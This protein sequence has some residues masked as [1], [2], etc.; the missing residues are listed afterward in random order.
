M[1]R[2]GLLAALVGF[3]TVGASCSSSAPTKATPRTTPTAEQQARADQLLPGPDWY[4][5]AV[6]YEV[7][8]RSFTDSNGDGIGDLVGLITRLDYLKSLGVDAIWLMPIM[9]TPF[10]DSGYDVSD[11]RKISPDYGDLAAFDALL[12]AAHQR[13]MRVMMD[14]VLNHTASEHA[15][16]KD[17]RSS[18]T[19][20]KADWY[21]WSDT[22]SRPDIGCGTYGPT[23]G[24][25]AW[26]FEPARNQYYFHRFYP[27]QPD[28]NYNNPEV[29]AETLD[30]AKFWLDKGV[31]GFRCDVIGL[32]YESAAGC[33]LIPQTVEYIKKLRGVLDAYPDRV[34][35]AEASL[36]GA[37]PYFGSGKDMFHMAFNFP[38]GYFWGLAFL[39][40]DKKILHEALSTVVTT[41]PPGAQDA[42]LIGS[43]DVP[44]AWT[45]AT[46]LAW[47]Q[48]R[49]VEIAMFTKATP[50][51]YY[52][53]ELGLH[54]GKAFVV[55]SRDS[56]RAPMPW[57]K[58]DGHGFSTGKPWLEL[59]EGAELTNVE[60]EDADPE[61]MLTFYRALLAFRR[62][63]PVW[64]T[65][66]MKMVTL[67]N[68]G[69]LAFVRRDGEEA[70]L[71]TA[72]MTEDEQEGSAPAGDLTAP[73]AV[74]WGDGSA[75]L[76][77]GTLHVKLAGTS[78]AV[79]ALPR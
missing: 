71:I 9:P 78:S 52:G 41:Y 18:K 23:F 16:F 65:G 74:V 77:G 53:E 56:A 43:H 44:R 61:S 49:A 33:D 20:A 37:T 59:A 28:L 29:V 7:D 42:S 38:Y 54:D 55:D 21:V 73:G 67:D 70:Y 24:D 13:K 60:A 30:T 58:A 76:V 1:R 48:R 50:F 12:V 62:G 4:R 26:T 75:S 10:K 19:S 39:G 45:K 31:D 17:S 8:V 14:L 40:R 35:V 46:G 6:F 22:P 27:E 11:Y 51:V 66:E 25:S 72:N 15:W 57:T 32:L 5:H 68:Q 2:L 36:G 3:V 47:R 79:F 69:I 64:G 34:M 63:H